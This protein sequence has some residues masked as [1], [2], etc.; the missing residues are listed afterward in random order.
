MHHGWDIYGRIW[1][2]FFLFLLP[3]TVGNLA[4][5]EEEETNVVMLYIY[6]DMENCSRMSASLQIY[7]CKFTCS[8]FLVKS[9]FVCPDS[10]ARVMVVVGVC[11]DSV[12]GSVGLGWL[13]VLKGLL[14]N[15]FC[16]YLWRVECWIGSLNLFDVQMMEEESLYFVIEKMGLEELDC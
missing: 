9:L 14:L 7:S 1:K 11:M 8:L 10:S 4:P 5:S 13:E 12:N 3:Q 16:R 2:L 15:L 6:H